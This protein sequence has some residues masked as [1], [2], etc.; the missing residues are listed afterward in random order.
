M[1]ARRLP[2]VRLLTGGT[3]M[4]SCSKFYI[5]GAWVE[6]NDPKLFDVINPATEEPIGQIM[7]GNARDVDAAVAAAK[8]AFASFSR[9][10]RDERVALL[11]AILGL[12]QERYAEMV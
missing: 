2:D 5:N 11:E 6:P 3:A 12:Y 8:A 7:L 1:R 10:S 4:K 9:T